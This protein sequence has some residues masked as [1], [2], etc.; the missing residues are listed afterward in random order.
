MK[1]YSNSPA[2]FHFRLYI[3]VQQQIKK[4]DTQ[5]QQDQCDP[6]AQR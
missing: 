1:L 2:F 6:R 3:S 5:I 4:E